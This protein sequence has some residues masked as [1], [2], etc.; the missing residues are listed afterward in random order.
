MVDLIDRTE[1]REWLTSATGFLANCE[2]CTSRDCVA[3]IVAEAIDNAPAVD[4]APV[5]HSRWEPALDED[6]NPYL[7]EDYGYVFRCPECGGTT[8][9]D[10]D[11]ECFAMY[12]RYC[13]AK[14]DG[15]G[16]GG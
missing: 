13:G 7:D 14:M 16:E 1:L 6:G 11:Q 4:A 5:V 15:G 3:C 12:C 8:I 2:D 9:G 10:C